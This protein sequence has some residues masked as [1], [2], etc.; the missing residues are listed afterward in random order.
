MVNV[1]GANKRQQDRNLAKS[2][3]ESP[4]KMEVIERNL[5]NGAGDGNRT[6]IGSLEG[7]CPTFR[8]RPLNNLRLNNSFRIVPIHH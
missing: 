6:R 2:S 5:V 8:P 7:Y 4:K 1:I 3:A